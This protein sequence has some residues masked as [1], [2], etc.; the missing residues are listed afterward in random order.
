MSK[1]VFFDRD[2]TVIED[3]AYNASTEKI[4]LLPGAADSLRRLQDAGYLIVIITNQSGVGRGYYQEDIVHG[5][6][7]TLSRL[8]N[9]AG[10]AVATYRHCPHAPED[11][12]NCRKPEPGMILDAA[13]ELA[14]ELQQSWMIGD[15]ESDVLAGHNAGCRSILIGDATDSAAEHQAANLIVAAD[16]ILTD[17]QD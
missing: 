10:V 12:C 2:G 17:D 7:E 13:E 5:Q 16:C 14:V 6:H 15:K 9:E 11:G 1:A 8:L 4:F 3:L